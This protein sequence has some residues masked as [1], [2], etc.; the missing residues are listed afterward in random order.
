[1][2]AILLASSIKPRTRMALIRSLPRFSTVRALSSRLSHA[3]S[4]KSFEALLRSRKFSVA[5]V[6][7]RQQWDEYQDAYEDMVR[8][9]AHKHA[10]WYVIPADNKWFTRLVV[11]EAVVKALEEMDLKYPKVSGELQAELE[12]ARQQLQSE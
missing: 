7:E 4:G 12:K 9:T 1:M 6:Q 11:A 3:S 8:H 5:D 2:T 10:P